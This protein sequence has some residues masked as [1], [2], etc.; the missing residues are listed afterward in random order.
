MATPSKKRTA[1][2]A[3]G[4]VASAAAILRA[5]QKDE[6]FLRQL[7]AAVADV[8][9]RTKGSLFYLHHHDWATLATEALYAALT[10]L[11]LRQTLGEEYTGLLLVSRQRTRLPSAL[12]SLVLCVFV[13]VLDE[14][15]RDGVGTGVGSDLRTSPSAPPAGILVS[16]L[17]TLVPPPRAKPGAV[18][19]GGC[20]A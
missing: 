14:S 15:P 13:C 6:V 8:L 20:P 5:A 19:T 7:H 9:Q 12:V 10:T 18:G 1:A 17:P 16:G 11:S 2:A 3:V 4:A